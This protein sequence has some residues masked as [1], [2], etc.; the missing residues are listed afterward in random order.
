MNGVKCFII[1]ILSERRNC[2]TVQEEI[3]TMH[4]FVTQPFHQGSSNYHQT[5]EQIFPQQRAALRPG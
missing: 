1:F 5:K 3:E 2:M 4:S